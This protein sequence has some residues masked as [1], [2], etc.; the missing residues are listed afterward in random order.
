MSVSEQTPI[1]Q[2]IIAGGETSGT[3]TWNLQKQSE[4]VVTKQLASTGAVVPLVLNTDYTVNQAGL[5][6]DSGGTINFLA[7]QIPATAGDIWTLSRNTAI[8]RSQD[9]ATKGAFLAKTINEQL[10][11]PIR[12][13]QDRKR[14]LDTAIRK[15]PGVGDNLNPLIP[16]MVDERALKFRD[17]GG[18][19]FEL[20]MSNFNPDATGD[21]QASAD[22]AAQSAADA[23]ASAATIDLSE[24]NPIGDVTPNTIAST[25]F[26]GPLG[27]TNPATVKATTF[28]GD[29]GG[30]TINK[31]STDG[32]LAGDSD[33]VVPTEQAV[34]TAIDTA[35]TFENQFLHI[36]D[37]KSTNTPGGTFTLG[38]ERTRDLNTVLT[39]EIT[40]ASL[41]SDQITLP[42]GTYYIEASAPAFAVNKHR[43]KVRDITGAADLII[44]TSTRSEAGSGVVSESN[45]HGRFIILV[46]SLV[47]IQHRG[48]STRATDGFGEEVN[49]GPHEVY[50]DVRIWR[51]N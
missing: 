28:E 29:A 17:S 43:I 51:I 12:I 14:D 20:V 4:L 46:S 25:R 8:D 22:A 40:G 44:G 50:T 37:Q 23:A 18:G 38:A 10:D 3:W 45:A 26:E 19:N 21:A 36:Q 13:A 5:D 41:A 6:N 39:N 31:F 47:E 30:T 1:N 35:S 27:S 9:F 11:N 48:A 42:A 34:K 24:P 2:F 7:P 32:T 15:D 49:V 33:D 16:Q